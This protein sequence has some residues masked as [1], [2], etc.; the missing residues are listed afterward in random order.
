M[1]SQ[2]AGIYLRVS[3]DKQ[4]LSMQRSELETYCRARG[5]D[6]FNFYEDI[7]TGTNTQREGLKALMRDARARKINVI[8][9]WKLDRLA[10]SLKDLVNTMNEL[11]EIGVMLISIKDQ[12]DMTTA[13]GRLMTHLIGAFAQFEADL[14]RSRV[15]AGIENAKRKGKTLGRP[16]LNNEEKIRELRSKGFTYGQIQMKLNVSK[17]SVWRALKSC[18][19]NLSKN[20]PLNIENKDDKD[21][22]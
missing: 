17:G 3:T 13:T 19:K 21:E 11:D 14:I 10:R 1:K 5:W 6:S 9:I 4:D 8:L 20:A 2:V 7:G 15:K 16:R 18:P 12:I 22:E